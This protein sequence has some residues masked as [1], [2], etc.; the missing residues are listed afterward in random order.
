M[1][2]SNSE[3]SLAQPASG[4]LCF[5]YCPPKISSS[6]KT[7]RLTSQ[8]LEIFYQRI[9]SRNKKHHTINSATIINPIQFSTAFHSQDESSLSLSFVFVGVEEVPATRSEIGIIVP[10]QNS[11]YY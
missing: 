7:C 10:A 4:H 8:K 2:F 6:E 3:I 5:I 11:K 1:L 9:I